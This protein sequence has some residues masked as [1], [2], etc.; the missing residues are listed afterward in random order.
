[1]KKSILSTSTCTLLGLLSRISRY[2]HRVTTISIREEK[3]R[4]RTVKPEHQEENILA[5]EK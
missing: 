2:S 4:K 5:K 1:M 3:Q